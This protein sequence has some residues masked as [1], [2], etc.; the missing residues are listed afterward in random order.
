MIA[1]LGGWCTK[2]QQCP[3]YTEADRLGKR[4]ERLCLRGQDG[5]RLIDASP[6]RTICIDVLSGRELSRENT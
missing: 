3:H 5:V 1:C 4:E 2:R 6:A